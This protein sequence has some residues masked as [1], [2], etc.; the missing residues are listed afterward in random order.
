MEAYYIGIDME[1]AAC[2]VGTPG[3]G[4][5]YGSANAAFAAREVLQEA[6]AAAR[7]LFD[8]G[9]QRV[10]LWDN[11]GGGVNFDYHQVDPRC[12][13]AL[14]RFH[15]RFPGI[16]ESFA[17]ILFIGYH[18][19]AST[20]D[21]ALSHTYSSKTYQY[22][23]ING[24]DVGEMEIDAAFAGRYGVPVLFASSDEAG[25]AQ[26]RASFAGIETVAVK[27]SF[28]WNAAISLHPET[29]QKR[30][31]EGVKRAWEKRAALKPF[32]FASPMDVAIR[33]QRIDAANAAK[34]YDRERKPF[35]FEDPYTRRGLLDDVTQLFD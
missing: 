30:I 3:E 35:A 8:C 34:L 20:K 26:A 23:R 11:H 5:S 21:A 18:A 27:K 33:F 24:R 28:G 29:A 19:S 17:G 15:T 12:E 2:V 14:G 10:I 13:I 31:Y 16:D 22:Y 9:A 4:L 25:A 6:N 7:A 1:G 32:A